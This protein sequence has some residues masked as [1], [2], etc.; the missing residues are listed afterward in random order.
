MSKYRKLSHM[1]YRCDYHIVFV[2]KYRYRIL[3]GAITEM[4]E[5]D[6]RALRVC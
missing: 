6:V 2:P 1:V 3:T 5:R 4:L